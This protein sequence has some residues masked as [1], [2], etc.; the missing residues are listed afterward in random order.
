MM[1]ANLLRNGCAGGSFF[2]WA[3]ALI[4]QPVVVNL[5]FVHVPVNQFVFDE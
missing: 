1:Q 5:W 4:A 3:F 2:C